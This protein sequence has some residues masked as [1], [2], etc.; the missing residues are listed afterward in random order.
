MADRA[1]MRRC[2]SVHLGQRGSSS[3]AALSTG[4]N[5][6]VVIEDQ[7]QQACRGRQLRPR[8]A[9]GRQPV[10]REPQRAQAA[11][12]PQLARRQRDQTVAAE[13]ERTDSCADGPD[14][15]R[16]LLQALVEQRYDACFGPALGP[17][18]SAGGAC[19]QLAIQ[20]CRCAQCSA[21]VRS[22]ELSLLSPY[23]RTAQRVG[24]QAR[25]RACLCGITGG[26]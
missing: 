17:S 10:P 1:S 15:R 5:S 8:H 23:D 6:R 7:R 20:H 4:R 22:S 9:C 12:P 13:L 25:V 2:T 21:Q 16:D 19:S 24:E 26:S 14:R 3:P 11:E 18:L